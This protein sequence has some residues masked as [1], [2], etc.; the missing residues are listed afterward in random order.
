M[1]SVSEPSPAADVLEPSPVAEVSGPSLA[2]G[3][4]E[5]S[6]AAV[7]VT[8][9][10]VMELVT[11]RYIDFPGV[12]IVDLNAP[13]L[14]GN[15][16]EM[17][18]VA[19]ERMFI[20]PSILEM[21]AS[22]SRALHQYKHASGFAPSAT[23]EAAEAVP[24]EPAAGAEFFAVV[25]VPPLTSEGQE[26]S[27]P[28]PAEA[29]EPTAAA[30]AVGATED[31]VGEAGSSSPHP[32]VAGADEAIRP[33]EPAAALQERIALEDMARATSPEFKEVEEGTG[34]ASLQGAAGGEAQTLDLACALWAATYESGNDAED[35]EEVTTRNTL[36][37]KLNW[38]RR[39]FDELILPATSVSLLV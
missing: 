22:V 33:D 30:V 28:Q 37:R 13:E 26:A 36:E 21:I 32:V 11:G 1:T 2:A 6:S 18:E 5:T 12:G 17:L 35:D 19:T 25:S 3:V 31:V 29:A 38:A 9:E 24:E 16:W 34:A 4:A 39:A 10:E 7:T 27:L 14:S 20:D 15:D 8:V 23:S